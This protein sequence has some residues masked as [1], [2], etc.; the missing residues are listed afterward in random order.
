MT[1]DSLWGNGVLLLSP[2]CPRG[3]GTVVPDKAAPIQ[4][5]LSQETIEQQQ[6]H[7]EH[8]VVQTLRYRHQHRRAQ[9]RCNL[10]F[11]GPPSGQA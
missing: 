2:V 3:F 9:N 5:Q 6:P 8:Q 11:R 10:C 7:E 1:L 4:P